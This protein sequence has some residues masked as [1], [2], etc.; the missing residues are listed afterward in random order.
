MKGREKK[1]DR[2]GRT[3]LCYSPMHRSH[4]PLHAADGRVHVGT[5][6]T[7]ASFAILLS[8]TLAYAASSVAT[9]PSDTSVMAELQRLRAQITTMQTDVRQLREE[10]SVQVRQ[11]QPTPETVPPAVGAQATAS[12]TGSVAAP[13]KGVPTNANDLPHAPAAAAEQ[14][15]VSNPS[16][17]QCL[18]TCEE[19]ARVCNIRA[20]KNGEAQTACMRDFQTC[21]A[22]CRHSSTGSTP[23]R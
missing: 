11:T 9:T 4:S 5:A 18:N 19:V 17:S 3:V 10:C 23:S 22:S 15:T 21:Q 12:T 13:G 16:T 2:T 7:L 6:L 8:G 14:P 20:G 1:Y